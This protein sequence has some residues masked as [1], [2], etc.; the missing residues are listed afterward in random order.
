M[1]YDF[2][3]NFNKYIVSGFNEISSFDSKFDTLNKFYKDF[4]KLK[5]VRSRNKD[6]KQKKIIVLKS[7]SLRY[8]E[9][10]DIYEKEYDQV[11]ESKDEDW[12][13]KHDYKNL[14]DLDYQPDKKD[15]SKQ[16]HQWQQSN[17]LMLPG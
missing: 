4:K 6:R 13:K 2:R 5:D 12:R 11:F 7:A 15:E 17:Q 10:I 14:K 16:P 9:L 3:R 1:I 8:D